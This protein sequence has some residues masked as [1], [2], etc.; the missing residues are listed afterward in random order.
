MSRHFQNRENESDILRLKISLCTQPLLSLGRDVSFALLLS[1]GSQKP[2]VTCKHLQ[3]HP[4]EKCQL[5]EVYERR[6]CRNS[7]D[8]NV[9]IHINML[10]VCVCVLWW[11]RVCRHLQAEESSG[12]LQ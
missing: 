7:Q 11:A 8:S 5:E 10:C 1:G 6:G 9:L 12:M 4:A 2:V 3:V